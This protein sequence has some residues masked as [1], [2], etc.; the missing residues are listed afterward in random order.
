[1][2]AEWKIGMRL[3]TLPAGMR[4]CCCRIFLAI[5]A[6]FTV[7]ADPP[8][9]YYSTAEGKLG[10]ELRQ[11]LHSV[12]QGH[13]VI[14]YSTGTRSDTSDALRVLDEDPAITNDGLTLYGYN[15]VRKDSFGL[16]TGWNR[17]HQWCDSYGFPSRRLAT[18]MA[19]RL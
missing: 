16:P 5:I 15:S 17:E 14:P 7:S 10:I 1:M 12:I 13:Q 2:K 9:G 3:D 4:S 19:P 6:P 8:P 18:S 11:A